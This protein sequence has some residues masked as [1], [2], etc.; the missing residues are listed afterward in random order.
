MKLI[1]IIEKLKT[2]DKKLVNVLSTT[3]RT[4]I[5]TGKKVLNEDNKEVKE[6]LTIHGMAEIPENDPLMKIA[7]GITVNLLELKQKTNESKAINGK[8]TTD[9]KE[10]RKGN[11]GDS[12]ISSKATKSPYQEHNR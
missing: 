8:D 11:K 10:R 5:K 7:E 4:D 1:L 12:K 3:L 6:L 9:S 2:K